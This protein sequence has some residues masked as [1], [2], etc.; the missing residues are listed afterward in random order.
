M[1]TSKR[2]AH[3]VGAQIDRRLNDFVT[4]PQPISLSD[5]ELDAE[6]QQPTVAEQPIPVR[7]WVRFPETPIRTTGWAVAWTERAVLVEWE[8]GDGRPYRAWVW[9]NAVER[10]TIRQKAE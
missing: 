1:G 9:A 5:R 4:R 8:D 10:V 2:Y 6:H 7:A 3:V